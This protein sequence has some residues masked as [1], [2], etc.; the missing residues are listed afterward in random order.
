MENF[1]V[2]RNAGVAIALVIGIILTIQVGFNSTLGKIAGSPL[3]AALIS[4][5]GGTLVL[6]LVNFSKILGRADWSGLRRMPWWSYLVGF[7]GA[8]YIAS[9]VTV[10]P[11][12]GLAAMSA[13]VVAGQVAGSLVVDKTGAM[14]FEKK[15]IGPPQWLGALLLPLATALVLGLADTGN[16]ANVGRNYWFLLLALVAGFTL[17]LSVGLNTTVGRYLKNPVASALFNFVGGA[18]ALIIIALV[19]LGSGLLEFNFATLGSRLGGAPWW[20]WLGGLMGALYVTGITVTGP[21]IGAALTNVL[22]VAGQLLMSLVADTAGLFRD[23]SHPLTLFRVA[24]VI[25]II[26]AVLLIKRARPLSENP[27]NVKHPAS[28]ARYPGQLN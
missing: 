28:S 24:G 8:F 11:E 18:I 17:S 7:N 20:A 5:L 16:T 12:V 3:L 22:T 6:G 9:T 21:A 1:K 23:Q 2:G 26:I 19:G 15:L 14:G 4:F 10:A 27:A 25:L 13:T